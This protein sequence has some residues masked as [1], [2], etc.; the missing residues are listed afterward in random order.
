MYGMERNMKH[1]ISCKGKV[2]IMAMYDVYKTATKGEETHQNLQIISSYS[3]SKE[4]PGKHR[5]LD[6]WPPRFI[7][8]P[9]RKAERIPCVV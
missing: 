5:Q 4:V 8:H 7:K 3:L 2:N 1:S 9:F 6:F